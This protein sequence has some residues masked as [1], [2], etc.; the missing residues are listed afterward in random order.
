MLQN[1]NE[2]ESNHSKSVGNAGNG[3]WKKK[4]VTIQNQW[5][6]Q[7]LENEKESDHSKSVG[8]ATN[9]KWK[10]KWPFKIKKETDE[11]L[12]HKLP[13]GWLPRQIYV[14]CYYIR[15]SFFVNPWKVSKSNHTYW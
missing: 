10:R 8:N 4:K 11:R 12:V 6:M 5:A 7:Q 9:E 1:E 14:S 15:F 2:K 3:K 13:D